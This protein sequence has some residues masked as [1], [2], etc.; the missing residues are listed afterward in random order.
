MDSIYNDYGPHEGYL[1]C[2]AGKSR[3]VYEFM[4]RIWPVLRP[5]GYEYW[6]DKLEDYNNIVIFTTDCSDN[7]NGYKIVDSHTLIGRLITTHQGYRCLN[8]EMFS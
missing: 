7:I 8:I 1:A 4:M 3:E 6:K 2:G 5:E